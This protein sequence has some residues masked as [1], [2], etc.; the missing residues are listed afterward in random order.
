MTDN[1]KE[2]AASDLKEER[3]EKNMVKL[4]ERT[5]GSYSALMVSLCLLL[6][7]LDSVSHG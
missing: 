1:R 4:M 2:N 7:I 6:K 3:G 5:P